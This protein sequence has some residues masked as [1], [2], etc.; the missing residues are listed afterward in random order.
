M[1]D[2]GFSKAVSRED[3]IKGAEKLGVEL[4]DHINFC[5]EAMKKIKS[6]LGL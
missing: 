3:I 1:K 5:I 2:K 6:E 4:D